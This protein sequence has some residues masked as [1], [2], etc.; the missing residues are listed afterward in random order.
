MIGNTVRTAVAGTKATT[1]R[2]RDQETDVIV[3][4]APE[5]RED[6]QSILGLRLPGREDTSPD[7]FPVPL[8]AVAS[9]ELAG[10]TG[11]IRHVDQDL[12][13]TI[14]ADV[15]DAFNINQVQAEVAD[16]IA[17]YSQPGV[18]N[19]ELA[20][21]AG[22][23]ITMAGATD[24]QKETEAF[25]SWAFL[26]ALALITVILV[27]QFDSLAM[28]LIIL[29]TVVLSLIGVL[30]GLLITGTPFGIMMTGIGVISLAGIVVNNAIVLLDYVKQLRKS[31]M[32]VF[33]ALVQAGMIRF[34]P[35]VLTAITTILGL[36]PM[37]VGA[38]L[39]ISYTTLGP[40]PYPTFGC[41]SA[42]KAQ[43]GEATG[44]RGHFRSGIRHHPHTRHGA[45]AVQ[46]FR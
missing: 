15:P 41:C 25:L 45:H 42:D 44:H 26:V 14:R 36:I 4:L 28:P 37:A 39:Q 24:D 33:D 30:W 21:P 10:G 32:S 31:G 6:V 11:A 17:Q 38:A 46:Y 5:Y 9:Y 34:R 8:S 1:V 16:R 40:F 35:V 12:A 3:Q 23:N 19:S 2:E 29:C 20:L 27:T 7:T 13:V 22:F 43:A 18:D